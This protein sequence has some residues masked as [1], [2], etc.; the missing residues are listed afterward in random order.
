M[1]TVFST[2]LSIALGTLMSQ[3]P[4]N[5]ACPV[6]YGAAHLTGQ[7]YK[8]ITI[9][10]AGHLTYVTAASI[11]TNGSLHADSCTF[12]TVNINGGAHLS[13]CTIT[14]QITIKGGCHIK[15][16]QIRDISVYGGL[17][18]Q[19]TKIT[20]NTI[21]RGGTHVNHCEINEFTGNGTK[22]EFKDSTVSGSMLIEKP[23]NNDESWSFFSWIKSL[24]FTQTRKTQQIILTN[25]HVHGTISFE[26]EGGLVILQGSSQVHG[27]ITNGTIA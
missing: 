20:G 2:L 4:L 15:H 7:T 25:T 14:E 8:N 6:F 1:K 19:D 3:S 26:K 18:L 5:A 9:Y 11:K 21:V 17:H 13:Q 10:G 23:Y 22:N 16:S 27:T 24:F 12:D